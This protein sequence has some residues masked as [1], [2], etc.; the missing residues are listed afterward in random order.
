VP[1]MAPRLAPKGPAQPSTLHS[2]GI[3]LARAS[4]PVC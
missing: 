3:G 4:L 1:P 2:T